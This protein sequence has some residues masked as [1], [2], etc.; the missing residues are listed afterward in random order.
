M[1]ETTSGA[2]VILTATQI[3]GV[4]IGA[5]AVMLLTGVGGLTATLIIEE[6]VPAVRAASIGAFAA[7]LVA[8]LVTMIV[9]T[10]RGLAAIIRHQAGIERVAV[11]HFANLAAHQE[12]LEKAATD[13]F[14][15]TAKMIDEKIDDGIQDRLDQIEHLM[16]KVHEL[17]KRQADVIG[18]V[19][20]RQIEIR[21][22]ELGQRR[23]HR[24]G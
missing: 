6:E 17:L 20:E 24:S 5:A 12:R 13:H 22:D 21:D 11:E 14:A 8:G 18:D 23:N 3:R 4:T 7:L 1:P 10:L 16:V 15:A 19:V 2:A 9:A